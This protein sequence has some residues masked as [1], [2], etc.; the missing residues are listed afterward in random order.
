MRFF[1]QF[2]GLRITPRG[3]LL[4]DVATAAVGLAGVVFI[5]FVMFGPLCSF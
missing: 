4:A 1:D 5:I 3:Q 2:R